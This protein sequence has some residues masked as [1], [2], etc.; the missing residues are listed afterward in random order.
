MRLFPA[1]ERRFA[2]APLGA[3]PRF[4]APVSAQTGAWRSRQHPATGYTSHNPAF[5]WTL[6][7]LLVVDSGPVVD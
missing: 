5:P 4:L 3:M 2:D 1:A 6:D 7:P